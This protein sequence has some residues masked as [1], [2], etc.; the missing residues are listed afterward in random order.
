M[1]D[2]ERFEE[3]K[4]HYDRLARVSASK[5][6]AVG[7]ASLKRSLR[8]PYIFCEEWIA[9][10][11]SDGGIK[12]LDYGCGTG[13]HSVA[14]ALRGAEVTGIDISPV[15]IEAGNLLATAYGVSN[16]VHFVVGNCEYMPFPDRQFD[17]V[18][19]SGAM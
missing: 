11:I 16:R 15:S 8:Q 14:L 4:M 2:H 19:C 3:Q 10:K 18:Y 5:S 12:L 6:V 13:V 9:K 7:S 17:I 1:S